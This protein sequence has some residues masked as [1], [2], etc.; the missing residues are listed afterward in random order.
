MGKNPWSAKKGAFEIFNFDQKL[1]NESNLWQKL[2][3]LQNVSSLA[4]F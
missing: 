4:L 2:K 3:V 1:F